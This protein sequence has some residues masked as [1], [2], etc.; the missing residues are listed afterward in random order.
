[1]PTK[2]A[3]SV[4]FRKTLPAKQAVQF[5]GDFTAAAGTSVTTYSKGKRTVHV[6]LG[7]APT[8]KQ[9][10]AA[11]HA[12]MRELR[13]CKVTAAQVQLPQLPVAH[14]AEPS[15]AACFG[16]APAGG[17]AATAQLGAQYAE[18]SL[19]EYD[20]MKTEAAPAVAAAAGKAKQT[21]QKIAPFECALTFA[22]SRGAAKPLARGKIIGACVNKAR[23]LGNLR[24]ETASPGFIADAAAALAA[25]DYGGRKLSVRHVL[26]EKDLA[27][28]GLNLH[29]AVGRAAAERPPRLVVLEYV[30]NPASKTTT[31]LVGKGVTM[32]TGGL[33]VKPYGSMETMHQD[34]MGAAGVFGAIDAIHQLQL[35][36]NVVAV[37]ALAENAIGSKAFMPTSILTSL[38]GTTVEILNTDAE[39]RLVLADAITFV[40]DHA[41]LTKKVGTIID[42]AT[43][44]GAALVAL[45][46]DRA[47][48][49]C[50]DAALARALYL[51]GARTLEPLWPLPVGA[52][53]HAKMKGLLSDLKNC[54]TGRY[55]GTSTAAAFL[56]H[57][58]NDGVRWAHLDIAGPGIGEAKSA[59]RPAGAPGFGVQL[60]VDYFT[61]KVSR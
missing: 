2:C 8:T 55:G 29:L 45:G 58:V 56:Q 1:M 16:A 40:Q 6:G 30:G 12:A 17:A 34:M 23:T 5:M 59:T 60:L 26:D 18:M 50:N 21:R 24:P 14:F 61:A 57:F 54:A 9:L 36:V 41:R 13:R 31:A 22:A 43:L 19:Y 11:T 42:M 35:P 39:G 7:A 28:R 33:N 49:C 38:K 37:L 44:T 10:R 3:T 27:A 25:H 32:D 4:V 46:E 20:D 48:L 47:A 52:E 53:H 51:S 15:A